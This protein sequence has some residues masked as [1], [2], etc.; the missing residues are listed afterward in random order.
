MI[1]LVPTPSPVQTLDDQTKKLI[2][3][4]PT[5]APA[6]TNNDQ[7]FLQVTTPIPGS[8]ATTAPVPED[9]QT[10]APN[11]HSELINRGDGSVAGETAADLKAKATVGT[12]PAA[13]ATVRYVTSAVIGVTLVVLAF[14]QFIAINPSYIPPDTGMERA[15]APNAWELPT[16]VAFLQSV[17][18]L[19]L[20]RNANVPQLFYMN[21]LDSLSW[22]NML[23]RGSAPSAAANSV[24]SVQLQSHR[25]LASTS[26]AYDATGY[27]D[28]SVRSNVAEKDWFFRLWIALLV[29]LAVLLVVVIGTALV[30]SWM[31]KRGNPFHSETSDS[32]KRSVSLRSISRRLLGMCVTVVFF[33][34]LPLSMVSMFE[35]LQDASSSGFPHTNAV[36]S[37]ITLALLV[38]CLVAG[39]VVVHRKS[40]AGLSRWQVRVVWGVA[41]GPYFYSHRLFFVVT[42]AVQLL[43]GVLVASVTT[44]G[45]APLIAL[46]VLHAVYVVVMIVLNPF[47]C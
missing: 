20:A 30:S 37:M 16:F 23:I 25:Q 22:L 26:T 27:I 6:A 45:A 33:S 31:V 24:S 41:Y 28:F 12:E 42:T 40:E 36:L 7:Q 14:F 29:V 38:G 19:S 47:Q 5:T 1:P 11:D 13:L 18:L 32:H 10:A 8:N 39:A 2:E 35:I 9:R 17:G 15:F 43:S 34:Y 4:L 21:F 44:S 3:G 46:I